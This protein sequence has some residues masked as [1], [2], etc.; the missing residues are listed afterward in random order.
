[1]QNYVN[2]RVIENAKSKNDAENKLI[3]GDISETHTLSD[4]IIGLTPDLENLLSNYTKK[5]TKLNA[6]LIPADIVKWASVFTFKGF[7]ILVIGGFLVGFGTRYAGGCTS[8]HSIMGISAM[9][10]ASLLATICFMIGGFF[11]AN[12]VLPFILSH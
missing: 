2:F 3:D 5:S 9:N 6:K 7:F 1:M 11:T 4:K 12:L 10:W 8:G